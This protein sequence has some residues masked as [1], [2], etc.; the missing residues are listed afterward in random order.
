MVT[1]IVILAVLAFVLAGS[2]LAM[3][4]SLAVGRGEC[5]D[6]EDRLG[7]A[8][9]EAEALSVRCRDLGADLSAARLEADVLGAEL[10]RQQPTTDLPRR[11]PGACDREHEW[12]SI[13]DH[14]RREASS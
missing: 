4:V 12:R 10:A 13:V 3:V 8:I 2:C 11:S 9:A 1:A 5:R 6:L 7:S 14:I